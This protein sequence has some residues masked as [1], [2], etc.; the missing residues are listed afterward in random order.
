MNNEIELGDFIKIG[1]EIYYVN[2]KNGDTIEIINTKTM[3]KKEIKKNELEKES[4]TILERNNKKGYALQNDLLPNSWIEIR[5]ENDEKVEGYIIEL[6]DDVI[7]VKIGEDIIYIDFEYNGLPKEIKEIRKIESPILID[8]ET[9]D[10]DEEII[11]EKE[12]NIE[13]IYENVNKKMYRYSLEDQLNDLLNNF[14]MKKERNAHLLVSRFKQ[15]R[16]KVCKFDENGNIIGINNEDESMLYNKLLKYDASN[17]YWIQYVSK[18]KR[19]IYLYHDEINKLEDENLVDIDMID[20][21][22][23]RRETVIKQDKLGS[24]STG[25]DLKYKTYYDN[26]H[27]VPFSELTNEMNNLL[28][29]GKI[30]VNSCNVI[31]NNL[32]DFKNTLVYL[33]NNVIETKNGIICEEY[34][35]DD[36]IELD[37]LLIYPNEVIKYNNVSLP[38]TNILTR[39]NYGMTFLKRWEYLDSDMF[40][41]GTKIKTGMGMVN[42][43][44]S[45]NLIYSM[46]LHK[47]LPNMDDLLENYLKKD[48]L[49]LCFIKIIK[50]LEP[51]MIYSENIKLEEYKKIKERVEGD[52]KRWEKMYKENNQ[53]YNEIKDDR[54]IKNNYSWIGET[55][56]EKY[57]INEKMTVYE[58]ITKITATDYGEY[59]NVIQ[60]IKGIKLMTSENLLNEIKNI[61]IPEKEKEKEC[62]IKSYENIEE[63]RKENGNTIILENGK[64][65]KEGDYAFIGDDFYK[66]D[67]K[68]NWERVERTEELCNASKKCVMSGKKCISM[69]EKNKELENKVLENILTEFDV[70][71]E[72]SKLKTEEEL[73]KEK[74]KIETRLEK[75]IEIN[76]NKIVKNNNEHY[77]YGEKMENGNEI[78]IKSPYVSIRDE[79]LS[80]KDFVKKQINIIEFVEKFTRTN[81]V[82]NDKETN[83]WLYCKDT[84]VELLPKFYYTLAKSYVINKDTYN[85]SG[86]LK[87]MDEILEENG[88]TID[89]NWVDKNSGFI[90]QSIDYNYDEGYEDGFKIKTSEIVEEEEEI[91]IKLQD[92]II[93]DKDTIKVAQTIKILNQIFGINVEEYLVLKI[94][95]ENVGMFLPVPDD[96]RINKMIAKDLTKEEQNDEKIVK[97]KREMI[98]NSFKNQEL[99]FL[100]ISGYII[101]LQVKIPSIRIRKTFYNCIYSDLTKYPLNGNPLDLDT[102]R[103]VMCVLYGEKTKLSHKEP[104]NELMNITEENMITIIKNICGELVSR[105]NVID[106]LIKEKNEYLLKNREDNEIIMKKNEWINFMPPL[107]A[108]KIQVMDN[109]KTKIEHLHNNFT[110]NKKDIRNQVLSKI[111][112]IS[113]MIEENIQNIV[114]HEKKILKDLMGNYFIDNAC[115]NDEMNDKVIDFFNKKCNNAINELNN[116]INELKNLFIMVKNKIINKTFQSI[117]NTKLIYPEL[118]WNKVNESVMINTIIH[119]CKLNVNVDIPE[120]LLEICSKKPEITNGVTMYEKVKEM[121]LGTKSKFDKLL[122][123]IGKR[124]MFMMSEKYKKDCEIKEKE[125][126]DEFYNKIVKI[127]NEKSDKDKIYEKQ[128]TENTK[129]I[130]EIKKKSETKYFDDIN[131]DEGITAEKIIFLKEN[132]RNILLVYPEIIKNGVDLNFQSCTEWGPL[133]L[134][135]IEKIRNNISDYY[136][137][138]MGLKISE[139]LSKKLDELKKYMNLINETCI[140]SPIGYYYF[141]FNSCFIEII[142]QIMNVEDGEEYVKRILNYIFDLNKEINTS[143]EKIMENVFKQ[144]E[145]EKNNLVRRITNM[146]REERALMKTEKYLRLGEWYTGKGNKLI[147][148]Y[149]AKTYDMESDQFDEIEDIQAEEDFED[150][151]EKDENEDEYDELNEFKNEIELFDDEQDV[152]DI[153]GDDLDDYDE[154]LINDYQDMEANTNMLEDFLS[155]Q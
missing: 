51:F 56:R 76:V 81:D 26:L 9:E 133:A 100:S 149:N 58:T 20:I 10:E 23:D 69:T 43:R 132:I 92:E 83:N 119:Y 80:E 30:S 88:I 111:M 129:K 66:R 47:I 87:K 114:V 142:I 1:Q 115:C 11:F 138:F 28:D 16:E 65:I 4:I 118:N 122:K 155:N 136:D 134:S 21:I 153:L 39:A 19:R 120:Y 72:I 75:V 154:D 22:E 106:V 143:Y 107:F 15:L 97:R 94:I 99:L 85:V 37:S 17:I 116:R 13:M 110:V 36:K 63:L 144:K 137:I 98:I 127:L 148:N 52:V 55:I 125:T 89:G 150:L 49:Y 12:M 38:M 146:N 48:D 105:M 31:L 117:I 86:Y 2:N 34:I 5:L 60:A 91:K 95:E 102:I 128:Q 121:G 50:E 130:R 84:G 70:N 78:I 61:Q 145:R 35:K 124:N 67:A 113:L 108:I 140:E 141:I 93:K 18:A 135:H 109:I 44:N 46:Y 29:I 7:E 6:D 32:G 57:G 45:K 104:F 73:E 27:V 90:I 54:K 42:I 101:A 151:F 131:Y 112:Y 96:K 53:I 139:K 8:A 41:R 71:Y 103:F 24:N 68:D 147:L 123:I 82:N 40:N 74:K 64:K 33:N 59:N 62:K 152:Y 126:E 14:L 3:E 79:I 25:S 77:E